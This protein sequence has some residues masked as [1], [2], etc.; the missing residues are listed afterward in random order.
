MK[1]NN[2]VPESGQVISVPLKAAELP[3]AFARARLSP[4]FDGELEEML[5]ISQMPPN[6]LEAEAREFLKEVSDLRYFYKAY[7]SLA[8]A[9]VCRC[10]D[11]LFLVSLVMG[12]E[13]FDGVA[14]PIHAE[15]RE[16]LRDLEDQLAQPRA[17]EGCGEKVRFETILPESC[18][19]CQGRLEPMPSEPLCGFRSS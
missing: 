11:R 8:S 10:E 16:A 12:D 14:A 3:L 18:Y 4:E 7:G 2:S 13:W 5:T 9:T 15:E 1:R 19:Q 6:A 17:R